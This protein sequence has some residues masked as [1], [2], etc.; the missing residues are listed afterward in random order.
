VIEDVG[1]SWVQSAKVVAPKVLDHDSFG[2]SVSLSG[3][4]LV[5][6]TLPTLRFPGSAHVFVHGGSSWVHQAKLRPND[7]IAGSYFGFP[8]AIE[9]DTVMV[10]AFGNDDNGPSSGAVYVFERTGVMWAERTKLTA[11]N[12]LNGDLFGGSI[13]LEGDRALIGSGRKWFG[14]GTAYMFERINQSWVETT[15]LE[16]PKF[17]AQAVALDGDIAV[18]GSPSSYGDLQASVFERSG[19]AWFET[20]RLIPTTPDPTSFVSVAVFD[21]TVLLGNPRHQRQVPGSV[22]V[23]LLHQALATYCTAKPNSLGCEPAISF[24]GCPAASISSGFTVLASDVRN[25]KPGLLIHGTNGRATLPFSG[26]ILCVAPPLQR[27]P[28]VGSGGWPKPYYNNCTGVYAI[29]MAAFATGGLGGTPD[30]QLSLPGTVVSC[31]W[32]GRDLGAS[33]ATTLSNALEYTVM[34]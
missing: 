32:W 28:V 24:Q 1:G 8:V 34:P 5:V 14:I 26:G 15:R 31:Q 22:S 20:D 3:D 33:H 13:A 29:D 12:G 7:P 27:T 6:G 30:P 18:L 10:G 17:V 11:S 16:V 19:T 4:T 23:F 21:S 2:F 9:E 25:E